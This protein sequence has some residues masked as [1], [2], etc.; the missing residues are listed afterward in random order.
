LN[1]AFEQADGTNIAKIERLVATIEAT[2]TFPVLEVPR[3][4]L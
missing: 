3:L 4:T 1:N 2:Y